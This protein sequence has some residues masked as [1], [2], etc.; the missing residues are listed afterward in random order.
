MGDVYRLAFF[1]DTF[2]QS[3]STATVAGQLLVWRARRAAEAVVPR[4]L[5]EVGRMGFEETLFQ[6]P[7]FN[8]CTL[9]E[10]IRR[11]GR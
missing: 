1:I 6:R 5:E 7:M 3:F 4:T 11:M 9:N 10:A 2:L 8:V